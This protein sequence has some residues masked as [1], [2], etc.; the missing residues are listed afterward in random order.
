MSVTDQ[1]LSFSGAMVTKFALPD[2]DYR[3]DVKFMVCS[4]LLQPLQ[5]ILGW[6]F[7]VAHKLQL[8]F[9]GGSYGLVGP[10]KCTPLN[11]WN[12]LSTSFPTCPAPS[13][14]PREESSPC[15]TQSTSQGL[16]TLALVDS[17]SI[18]SRSENLLVVKTPRGYSNQLGMVS[19]RDKSDDCHYVVAFTLNNATADG[20]VSVRVMNPS[21]SPIQL[22]KGQKIAQFQPVFESI[23]T[24]TQLSSSQ[25]CS[26]INS[27]ARGGSRHSQHSHRRMSDFITEIS[28]CK[29]STP[30]SYNFSFAYLKEYNRVYLVASISNCLVPINQRLELIVKQ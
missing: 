28:Y 3:Y 11:P 22:Y 17:I 30:Q 25:I 4:N 13:S 7:I 9:L 18:P 2:C 29:Q 10:H 19:P 12:S 15:F 23:S 14:S 20:K 27:M 8:S 1:P 6:D 16:V 24:P 5:C 21:D 26:S